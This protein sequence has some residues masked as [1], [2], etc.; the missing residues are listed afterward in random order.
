[1]FTKQDADEQNLIETYQQVWEYQVDEVN[2]LFKL[3][4][5]VWEYQVDE[6]NLLFKLR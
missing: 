1:M 4:L 5:Q 3:R 6:V 2:L